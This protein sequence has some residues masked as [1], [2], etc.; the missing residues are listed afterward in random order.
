MDFEACPLYGIQSKKR[1]KCLLHLQNDDFFKQDYTASLISPYIDYSTKPRL[2]EPPRYNLKCVQRRIKALLDTIS[3]PD[4]VFSGVKGRS[5][6]DNVYQHIFSDARYFYKADIRAFFPSI[7]RE[8]VYHFFLSDLMCSPDVASILASLTTID[9]CKCPV[10]EKSDLYHF[11]D[12]KGIKCYNHL[13]SGAPTSPILSYLA[14]HKMFDEL[15]KLSSKNGIVMT[16]YV[17]DLFFSS[18]HVISSKFRCSVTSVLRKNGYIIAK[19]KVKGYTKSYPKLITGVIIDSTGAPA[20]KNSL[21]KKIIEEFIFLLENP[22]NDRK[23]LQGLVNAARQIDKT[24]YPNILK[25]AYN[26]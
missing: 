10:H 25:F 24:A 13:I 20:V 21:H 26:L 9:L 18:E 1:L 5:Y 4:N 15:Q 3:I 16:I 17:D 8:V 7:S 6:I 2:I 19:N 23:R 14:N 11:L 22:T 12:T